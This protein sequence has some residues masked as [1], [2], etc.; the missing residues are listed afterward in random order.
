MATQNDCVASCR[1]ASLRTG[2][3]RF[4]LKLVL[5]FFALVALAVYV[6]N[7]MLRYRSALEQFQRAQATHEVGRIT[8]D[9]LIEEVGS[10]YAAESALLWKSR[11]SADVAYQQR[12]EEILERQQNKIPVI[13][14]PEGQDACRAQ[15]V[16]IRTKLAGLRGEH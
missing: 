1:K 7:T 10:L 11:R 16:K 9:Q 8:T 4:S 12:L 5:G 15:I 3:F 6:T 2:A 14:S 13:C